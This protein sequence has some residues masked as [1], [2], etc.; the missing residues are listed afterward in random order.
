MIASQYHPGDSI[1]L[2]ARSIG[3]VIIFHTLHTHPPAQGGQQL[4]DHL[5]NMKCICKNER[6]SLQDSSE[7][8]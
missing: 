6:E 1:E 8:L 7:A 4:L 2:I 5:C 3:E